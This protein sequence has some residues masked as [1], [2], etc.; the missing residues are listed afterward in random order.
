M[1]RHARIIAATVK[2]VHWGVASVM[3]R[4]DVA[5]KN[6]AGVETRKVLKAL[7]QTYMADSAFHLDAVTMA[8]MEE[9]L[10]LDEG[11]EP[12]AGATTE[13]AEPPKKKARAVRAAASSAET[14]AVESD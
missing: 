14:A 5:K 10:K 6:A 11:G 13:P 8:R 7:K 12:P 3:S 2:G 1:L 9:L 4:V